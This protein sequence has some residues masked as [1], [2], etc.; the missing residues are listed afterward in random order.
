MSDEDY[1]SDKF[2]QVPTSDA[3]TSSRKRRFTRSERSSPPKQKPLNVL[4]VEARTNAMATQISSENKG[5]KL[6][7]RLGYTGGG[8]GKFGQGTEIPIELVSQST[9]RDTVSVD[10]LHMKRKRESVHKEQKEKQVDLQE[11]LAHSYKS[12]ISQKSKVF[13]NLG[14]LRNSLKILQEFSIR[15]SSGTDIGAESLQPEDM[16][17]LEDEEEIQQHLTQTNKVSTP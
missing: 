14:L 4:M 1:L 8:L 11:G 13:K 17:A 10:T 12:H 2:L 16:D 15:S 7:S 5:F 6:L 3:T 9:S